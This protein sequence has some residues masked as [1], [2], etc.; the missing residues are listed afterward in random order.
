MRV[1]STYTFKHGDCGIQ[2]LQLLLCA[3]SFIA[4]LL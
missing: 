3:A 2:L 1:I 4:K